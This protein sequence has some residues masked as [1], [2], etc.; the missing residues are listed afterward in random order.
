M[1]MNSQLA[2]YRPAEVAELFALLRRFKPEDE[3][4]RSKKNCIQFI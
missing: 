3:E 2:E 1:L 4:V